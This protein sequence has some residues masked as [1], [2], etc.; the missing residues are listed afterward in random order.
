MIGTDLEPGALP[1]GLT[2]E[3][4]IEK[5]NGHAKGAASLV[6]LFKKP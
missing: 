6:G 1:P 5:L 4:L 3:Q 2:Y